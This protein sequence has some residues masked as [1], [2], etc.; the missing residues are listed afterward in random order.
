MAGIALILV[1]VLTSEVNNHALVCVNYNLPRQVQVSSIPNSECNTC[2]Q[3]VHSVLVP[4][5]ENGADVWF[6]HLKGKFAD[7]NIPKISLNICRHFSRWFTREYYVRFAIME[8]WIDSL[9]LT[10]PIFQTLQ[11]LPVEF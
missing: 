6:V 7:L 4:S 9:N 10:S 5:I 2:V 11:Y 3:C 1:S 8:K